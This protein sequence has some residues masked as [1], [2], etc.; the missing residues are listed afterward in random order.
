MPVSA[1]VRVRKVLVAD[2]LNVLDVDDFAEGTRVDDVL[3]S[4][5]IWRI[6]KN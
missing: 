6:A 1:H 2:G 5:I 4:A 3:D